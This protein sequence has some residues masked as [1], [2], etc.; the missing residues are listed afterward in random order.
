MDDYSKNLPKTIQITKDG[1]LG[2]IFNGI[3][4]WLYEEEILYQPSAMFWSPKSRFLAYIKFNDSNV[5]YYTFPLYDGSKYNT[6]SQIRYP[7]TGGQNPIVKMFVHDTKQQETKE[8][9]VP[10]GLK[11]DRTLC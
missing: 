8:L 1:V 10:E 5:D 11:Y 4:D 7:K 3:T 9:Q 2:T 6:L